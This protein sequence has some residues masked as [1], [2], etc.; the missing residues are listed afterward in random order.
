MTGSAGQKRVPKE[1]F[2]D[3]PFPLPPLAE[4]RRIV[5]KVEGLMSLCETLES[6]RRA[7]E[8][9][10]ERAS[11]SVL[12]RLTSAP[13]TTGGRGSRRAANVAESKQT[14]GSGPEIGS[15][16]ASPS[17]AASPKESLAS[18]WQRLSDHFEVLLDQPSGPAHLRQS[19]LQ[20]AVQGKL[21]PQDPSDEPA[22]ELLDNITSIKEGMVATGELRKPKPLSP[23]DPEPFELPEN[24]LWTRLGNIQVFTN[25]FAFKSTEYQKDG[26]GIVRIGDIQDGAINTGN[27]KYVPETRVD[28]LDERLQ[29]RPGHMLIAMSG[30][31]TGKLGFNRTSET[32]LLNQRVGKIELI[33]VDPQFAFFFLSTK[34]QENLRQSAGSAIPNLSTT[35][36]N[37]LEFPLAP[38][39]EQKRIVSKVSV[40]LLQLDELSARLRSRQ[41]TTDA[42]LTALIHNV[43]KNS[44]NT[45]TTQR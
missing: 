27:L 16:G 44:R 14:Y 41:S 33:E 25:G 12:V 21:V 32:F 9:V 13:R 40:L 17:Q 2:A 38:L 36:I 10:R 35:Q 4:Q 31:T 18:A 3:T 20:L 19:I 1:Y 23:I 5:S 7:R 37:D 42:L 39:A 8:S 29:V 26:V 11:R 34:I 28:E 43:L 30:A 15:A 24:W 6:H 45:K 22:N